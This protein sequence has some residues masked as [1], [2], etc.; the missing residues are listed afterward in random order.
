MESPEPSADASEAHGP[1]TEAMTLALERAEVAAA[2]GNVPVGAVLLVD[3]DVVAAAGNLRDTLCDPTAHAEL[4]VLK[5]A[6]QRLGRWRLDDATLVVTLEP[7]PMCAAALSQARIRT[8][9]YGVADP[10]AGGVVS[11]VRLD[12]LGGGRVEVVEGVQ[13]QACAE[14]LTRFFDGLRTQRRAR[15]TLADETPRE[16]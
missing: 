4:L 9:V 10:K 6:G 5:Q 2:L 7:C 8:L 12:A 13:A 14:V 15:R 1:W 16:T 11:T 3:G